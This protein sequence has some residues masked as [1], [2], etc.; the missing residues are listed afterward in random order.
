MC[1]PCWTVSTFSIC[2]GCFERATGRGWWGRQ[3]YLPFWTSSPSAA[4]RVWTFLW[5]PLWTSPSPFPGEETRAIFPIVFSWVRQ[6]ICPF[7]ISSSIWTAW[8]SWVWSSRSPPHRRFAWVSPV[9]SISW[10]VPLG[11]CSAPLGLALPFL[12]VRWLRPVSYVALL[13]ASSCG[14]VPRRTWAFCCPSW[15][16]WRSSSCLSALLCSTGQTVYPPPACIFVSPMSRTSHSHVILPSRTCLHSVPLWPS[17][18]CLWRAGSRRRWWSLSS[19]WGVSWS[20]PCSSWWYPGSR[21]WLPPWCWSY[22]GVWPLR[23]WIWVPRSPSPASLSSYRTGSAPPSSPCPPAH[24]SYSPRLSACP[25]RWSSRAAAWSPCSGTLPQAD[26]RF[27]SAGVGSVPTAR[28]SLCSS[29]S[30]LRSGFRGTARK[31]Q[32]CFWIP[33]R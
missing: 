33:S 3:S 28:L 13:V 31:S 32:F 21:F 7:A 4:L 23:R 17:G 30:L 24:L 9:P 16:G 1:C 22:G 25:R 5:L 8:G 20:F 15:R 29:R 27:W 12:T 11:P 10:R 14:T 6:S 18:F 2:W 26:S 19:C